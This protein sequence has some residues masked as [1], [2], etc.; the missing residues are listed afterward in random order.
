VPDHPDHERL[1]AFQAGE[2]DRRERIDVEAHLAGCPACAEVV[3]SVERARGRLALLEE[4]PLPA[5]LHDRL[6]AAVEDEA[7]RTVPDRPTPWYRRSPHARRP[8][9]SDR[10]GRPTPWYRRPA[11]WG[12]AAA[13]LLAA[14]VVP[15]IDQSRTDRTT[16]G[17]GG[18]GQEAATSS[19]AAGAARDI[20]LIRIPGEV[21]AATVNSR[22]D[23]DTRARSA[24]DAAEAGSP[25]AGAPGAASP[26]S[27][28]QAGTDAYGSGTQRRQAQTAVPQACLPAATSAADPAI[29]PLTPVFY[30]EGR[31]KG[32]EA[33]ILVTTSAR[34]TGRVDLWVFPRDD[35][36]GPPLATELV[37]GG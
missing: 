11:A 5:G 3:A 21:S 4:P 16:A 29:T 25:G 31:Y 12:A 35:C 6:A 19:E 27:A 17:G 8:A 18:G 30:V 34:Q 36:S 20:P 10:Q 1:A 32:R 14:L 9:A 13:L 28:G 15:F 7:A 26:Q 24:L 33:T 2:V 37:R 23:A 22:L